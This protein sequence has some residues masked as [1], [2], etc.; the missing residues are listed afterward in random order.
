LVIAEIELPHEEEASRS[1]TGWAGKSHPTGVT[2]TPLVRLPFQ[3][4]PDA[5]GYEHLL[6]AAN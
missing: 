4:W 2:Q 3:K 1:R 6:S 5:S